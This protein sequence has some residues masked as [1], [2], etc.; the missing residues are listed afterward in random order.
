MSY[1]EYTQ[2][3]TDEEI[4]QRLKNDTFFVRNYEELAYNI[5]DPRWCCINRNPY[6]YPNYNFVPPYNL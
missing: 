6:Y 3:M 2:D 5:R 4:A 1:E